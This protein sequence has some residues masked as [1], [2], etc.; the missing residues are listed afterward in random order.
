MRCLSRLESGSDASFHQKRV[1]T[2]PPHRSDAATTEV[3]HP[4]ANILPTTSAMLSYDPYVSSV[5]ELAEAALSSTELGILSH[6]RRALGWTSR[7]RATQKAF[8][9][10]YEENKE[11][12]SVVPTF[13]RQHC[14]RGIGYCLEAS[15]SHSAS[16]GPGRARADASSPATFKACSSFISAIHQYTTP[17]VSLK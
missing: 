5:E 15:L 17:P 11:R 1:E 3:D 7:S 16:F 4:V 14:K 2:I 6:T 12:S 8:H 10:G 9:F 13:V